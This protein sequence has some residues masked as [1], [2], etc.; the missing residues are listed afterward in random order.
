M[1]K[2]RP[3]KCRWCGEWF[4]RINSLQKACSPSCGIKLAKVQRAKKEEK[5]FK[6]RKR[7]AK[8]IKTLKTEAQRAFNRYIRARDRNKPCVSCGTREAANWHASHYRPTSTASH[9]RF[10]ERNVHK[11]CAKCNLFLSGNLTKYREILI[12]K[13]GIRS[14]EGLENDHSIKKWTREELEAIRK[15]Y[16][17]KARELE[18]GKNE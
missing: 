9:L 1:K 6:E 5:D 11:S 2:P 13:I 18:R 4:Q 16:S 10:N 17:S 3:I 12:Y 8:P 14:V 15:E 7:R